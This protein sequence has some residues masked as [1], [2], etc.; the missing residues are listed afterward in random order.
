MKPCIRETTQYIKVVQIVAWIQPQLLGSQ[1]WH[2]YNMDFN[3]DKQHCND[4][5]LSSKNYIQASDS[6]RNPKAPPLIT[7]TLVQL[8]ETNKSHNII[9]CWVELIQPWCTEP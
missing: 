5:T 6:L 1:P 8:N 7:T 4:T 2:Q 3:L 9:Q